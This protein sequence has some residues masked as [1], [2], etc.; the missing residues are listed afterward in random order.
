MLPVTKLKNLL[1]QSILWGA[2]KIVLCLIT[3][4]KWFY[5]EDT[6]LNFNLNPYDCFKLV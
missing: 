4:K 5:V 6:T 2:I 1:D 3:K